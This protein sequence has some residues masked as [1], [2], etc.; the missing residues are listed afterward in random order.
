[1]TRGLRDVE[2]NNRRP[3]FV[4]TLRRTLVFSAEEPLMAGA[5]FFQV[6]LRQGMP[7]V[8]F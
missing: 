8:C 4:S 1:M 3:F 2:K 6:L 5:I 7:A